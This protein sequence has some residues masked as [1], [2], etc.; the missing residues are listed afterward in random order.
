MLASMAARNAT[1]IPSGVRTQAASHAT[2]CKDRHYF[3]YCKILHKIICKINDMAL[4]GDK[5]TRDEE[6]FC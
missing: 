1:L 6:T 2:A 4:K 3:S 5:E